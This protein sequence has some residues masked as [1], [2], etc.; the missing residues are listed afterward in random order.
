M[1]VYQTHRDRRL[2]LLVSYRKG[3]IPKIAALPCGTG[4]S[5][6]EASTPTASLSTAMPPSRLKPVPQVSVGQ[7]I[8]YLTVFGVS[9][10]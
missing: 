1:A 3:N 4:F 7:S 6:E 9:V 2:A 8:T 10:R 5:R